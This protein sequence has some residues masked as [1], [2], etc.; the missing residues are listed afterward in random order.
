[1]GDLLSSRV[2]PS[3]P[4][5]NVGVDYYGP[6]FIREGKRR[7]ARKS[8]AW[9]SIFVC[10]ATKAIH[11]EL[12]SDLTS[13]GFLSALKRF[14]GRRGKPSNIFSDNGT[15]FVGAN[16]ELEELRDLF[17]CE[18]FRHR[19]VNEMAADAITWHFIPPRAPHFGLWEA[20]V[21]STKYHLHRAASDSLTFEEAV[22]LLIQVEAILNSRPLTPLS[23]NPEDCSHLTP[24]HF[25]IRDSLISYPEPS[26][27]HLPMNRLSRWQRIEQIRQQF[28]K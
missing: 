2:T 5:S 6:I 7:N 20:T 16:R 8:K 13:E 22:T 17:N 9:I 23:S 21:R 14:I 27:Q 10:L 15:N 12:I 3:R 4:F 26:L 11:I 25:L 19:I 28:W 18:D 24:G 1:M